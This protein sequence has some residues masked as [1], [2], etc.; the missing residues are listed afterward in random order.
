MRLQGNLQLPAVVIVVYGS[1][2]LLAIFFKQQ[3]RFGEF[4][5]ENW[6]QEKPPRKL[7]KFGNIL[8]PW[9]LPRG[10]KTV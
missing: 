1:L 6:L 9:W 2:C 10:E 7:G 4:L 3:G 8:S 5:S